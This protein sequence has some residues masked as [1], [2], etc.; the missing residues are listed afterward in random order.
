[1]LASNDKLTKTTEK[2][3]T[4][5]QSDIVTNTLTDTKLQPAIY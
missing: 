1:M 3:E 2:N 5:K 4:T